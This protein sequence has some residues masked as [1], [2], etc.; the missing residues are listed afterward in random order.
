M[1]TTDA[2]P[3]PGRLQEGLINDPE[4]LQAIVQNLLQRLLEHELSQHLEAEPYQRTPNRKGYLQTPTPQDPRRQ[5]R[6]THPP[7]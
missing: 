6:T 3:N 4:Y 1:A 5:P 7:R 2:T